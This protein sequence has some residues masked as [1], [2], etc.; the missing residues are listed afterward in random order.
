MSFK[1]N[2]APLLV[3]RHDQTDVADIVVRVGLP[4]HHMDALFRRHPQCHAS[5]FAIDDA[6][7]PLEIEI[8]FA[9]VEH[10]PAASR[11]GVAEFEHGQR[12][13]LLIGL[14]R[15]HPAAFV[16][17]KHLTRVPGFIRRA[18]RDPRPR[19]LEGIDEDEHLRGILR[20]GQVH[21]QRA[22]RRDGR[23]WIG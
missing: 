11:V 15:P 1:P 7:I 14:Q 22:S 20:R 23:R 12:A 8:P 4:N 13:G 9:L 16:Q 3:S 21:S 17:I 10:R 5:G 18:V 6:S 2:R 19:D